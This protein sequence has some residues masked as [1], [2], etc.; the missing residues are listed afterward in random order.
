M[1]L[2]VINNREGKKRGFWVRSSNLQCTRKYNDYFNQYFV[3]PVGCPFISSV[4]CVLFGD[5]EMWGVLASL[6]NLCI[7]WMKWLNHVPAPY[8][9]RNDKYSYGCCFTANSIIRNAIAVSRRISLLHFVHLECFELRLYPSS[10]FDHRIPS[11]ARAHEFIFKKNSV[12][13]TEK[14]ERQIA[15]VR[16]VAAERKGEWSDVLSLS[17]N[18]IQFWMDTAISVCAWGTSVYN[19]M[20]TPQS[21]Y[22]YNFILC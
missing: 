12:G 7:S 19:V 17:R 13:L 16:W 21:N 2:I 9:T 4:A 11:F 15:L 6:W 3:Q 1:A 5:G 18:R 20:W 8:Y 14:S 10:L 22:V